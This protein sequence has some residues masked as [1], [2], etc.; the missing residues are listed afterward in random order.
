[1]TECY[2]GELGF[3]RVQRRVVSADFSGGDISSDGGVLLL[4]ETDRRIGLTAAMAK[5]V[6]D[7]RRRASCE[8]SLVSL[9][10][11]RVY[12]LALGYEDVNDHDQ[13]RFDG[14]LQTACNRVTPMGS[15][16]T[17]GRVERR[18]NRQAAWA[19]H[20]VLVEQFIAAFKTAPEA[21][22]LDFD[23]TDDPVHGKQEGRFFHGYYD[24]YCFLPLYVTCGDHLLVSY[25]RPSNI[26]AA[27]HA[28]AILSLLVKHLRQVW[29]GVR[30]IFRGDA[31]FCRHRMLRWCEDHG[32][33]YIVGIAKNERLLDKASSLMRVAQERFEKTQAPQRLFHT[34]AYAAGTWDRTRQVIVKAEHLA[35]GANPRFIVTNLE[36]DAQALYETLY[37]ARGDM[38]NKIKQQFQLFSDR[39]SCHRWWPNQFRLLLSSCAYVLMNALRRIGLRRTALANAEVGTLRLQLFKIGVAIVRNTRRIRF[40]LSSSYPRQALFVQ[41]AAHLES[42]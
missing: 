33:G 10:R 24:Q 30:I 6:G 7:S 4:R 39:T 14:A 1:M 21:L 25:L 15:S 5:A 29:P 26:D 9:L 8:H 16:S 37:C 36:G 11:Q 18:A 12:G 38:E 23:A 13:L 17:V 22:V 28:W 42:G 32:V 41:V 40:L 34:V 20:R 35:K 31:G 2:Q 3:G 19:L 27:W